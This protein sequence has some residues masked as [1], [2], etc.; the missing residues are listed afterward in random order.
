MSIR[1]TATPLGLDYVRKFTDAY[2]GGSDI[3]LREILCEDVQF[4]TILV[5]P[6]ETDLLAGKRV[7]PEVGYSLQFGGLG[8]YYDAHVFAAK[9]ADEGLGENEREEWKRLRDFWASEN[10]VA[11]CLR[12]FEAEVRERLPEPYQGGE[13]LVLPALPDGRIAAGL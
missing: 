13:N 6:R 8:Y 7:F 11:K 3:C 10:T 1:K 4:P 2:R 12:E 5:P 9:I